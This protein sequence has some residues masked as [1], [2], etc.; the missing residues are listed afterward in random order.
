MATHRDTMLA[1][2]DWLATHLDDPGLRV[3]D[4]RG[5]IKPPSAC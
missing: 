4:I 5:S 2:T 1:E 3:V